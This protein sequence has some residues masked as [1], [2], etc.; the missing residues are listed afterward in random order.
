MT[1][2]FALPR[3]ALVVDEPSSAR[4]RLITQLAALSCEVTASDQEA[5]ATALA[6]DAEP[7]LVLLELR[8]RTGSGLSL[9]R[10]LRPRLA[11][12]RFVVLTSYGSVA[13]AVNA[14]RLGADGYL[15]KPADISSV[16][17]AAQGCEPDILDDA[18]QM[19]TLDQAIWEYIHYTLETTG[20]L[21]EA[22]R[23]LGLWRQSL[24]RMISKY[25]PANGAITPLPT[26]PRADA[27]RAHSPPPGM[28]R[29]RLP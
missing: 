11:A 12:T 18:G 21:S 14:T 26:A 1:V 24:K 17:A 6:L 16:L 20:S 10:A 9:L 22:A 15:C 8:L 27:L 5:E 19:L 23:R 2:G 29:A 25:R 4:Q 7:D 3:R 28:P 13:T